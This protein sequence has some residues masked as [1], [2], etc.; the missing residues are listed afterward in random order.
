MSL[1]QENG[2]HVLLD[3]TVLGAKE[4]ETLRL[5]LFDPDFHIC[6]TT[7]VGIVSLVPPLKLE[8]PRGKAPLHEIE[9]IINSR[10]S[11]TLQCKALDHAD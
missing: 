3:A 11:N 2:W 10:T 6:S 7:N 9:E 8:A 5:S 4:M 1:V